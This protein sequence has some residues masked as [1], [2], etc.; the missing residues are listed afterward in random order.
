M[1]PLSSFLE[2]KNALY[3]IKSPSYHTLKLPAETQEDFW[4]AFNSENYGI[5]TKEEEEDSDETT[6]MRTEIWFSGLSSSHQKA[7]DSSRRKSENQVTKNM[8]MEQNLRRGDE[9]S[10]T[11]KMTVN[12]GCSN[13]IET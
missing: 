5:S 3:N 13:A 8:Y 2:E 1:K 6:E 11:N 12:A 9:D 4:R 7:M 10:P